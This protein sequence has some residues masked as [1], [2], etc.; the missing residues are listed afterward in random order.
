MSLARAF[1]RCRSSSS[2]L[3]GQRAEPSF[4]STGGHLASDN[5]NS[6]DVNNLLKNSGSEMRWESRGKNWGTNFK[7]QKAKAIISL[8]FPLWSGERL[9]VLGSLENAGVD[10]LVFRSLLKLKKVVKF[11]TA[12]K[13]LKNQATCW[14][15]RILH[16]LALPDVCAVL[17]VTY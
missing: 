12:V 1:Q 6:C 11:S 10:W 3:V 17:Q 8:I 9:D 5:S 16:L 14:L 2:D 15:F 7:F 13:I 4:T